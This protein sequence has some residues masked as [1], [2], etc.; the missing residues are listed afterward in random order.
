MTR[1]YVLSAL[2]LSLAIVGTASAQMR[3]GPAIS[4]PPAPP[5]RQNQPSP[6]PP[7]RIPEAPP[8]WH[9]NPNPAPA[10]KDFSVHDQ[11]LK[12]LRVLMLIDT[13]DK[14]ATNFTV[15]ERFMK[16]ILSNGI[17]A[18]RLD[19]TVL[20]GD[21]ATPRK[22]LDY[23]RNLQTGPEEAVLFYYAGHGA[24]DRARG[25]KPAWARGH[26]LA[27]N[28]GTLYRSDVYDAIKAK[29][30]GLTIILTDCCSAD[31][32]ARPADYTTTDDGAP[33][34]APPR[35]LSHLCRCL[36]FRH[37]GVVDRTAAWDGT[38]GY[39]DAGIG[40]WYTAAITRMFAAPQQWVP[41]S[42]RSFAGWDSFDKHVGW[43]MVQTIVSRG[44][45]LAQ[46]PCGFTH[47]P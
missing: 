8:G 12:R 6:F 10:S 13:N 20:R 9:T 21:D 16:A 2:M 36:F 39:S 5:S 35:E 42:G 26:Y 44:H 45:K 19:I 27:L 33:T 24:I 46:M 38:C 11:E 43:A 28:A 23:Y 18:S 37:R 34:V 41:D 32:P 7:L 22:V 17:P 3:F 47:A 40:N 4:A 30:P 29:N 15:S 25:A 14:L 1:R 31:V